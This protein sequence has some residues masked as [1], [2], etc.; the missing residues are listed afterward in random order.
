[1][2][3]TLQAIRARYDS[4]PP[5]HLLAVARQYGARYVLLTRRIDPAPA[6]V[7]P[8]FDR[9]G[10]YFLYDLNPEPRTLTPSL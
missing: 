5:E 7:M 1:M 2:G 8:V 4:L 10:R 3:R 6:G 9:N